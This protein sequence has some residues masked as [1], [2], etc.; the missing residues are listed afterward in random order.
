MQVY[1]PIQTQNHNHNRGLARF[2]L[3]DPPDRS[4]FSLNPKRQRNRN[5]VPL[6]SYRSPLSPTNRSFRAQNLIFG[7]HRR[8]AALAAPRL[9]SAAGG[10]H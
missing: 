1:Q 4:E 10:P 7:L 8:A 6:S 9:R 2:V 5:A 3:N